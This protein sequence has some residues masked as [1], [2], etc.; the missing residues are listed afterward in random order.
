MVLRNHRE[1]RA[2][3]NHPFLVA[4]KVGRTR[5]LSWTSVASIVP[6]DELA[7]VGT[8][9]DHGRPHR[10]DPLPR[11][12]HSRNA[13]TAPV[14][15]SN[16]LLWLLG[17]YVGDGFFDG[18]N[19]VTF[20]VPD[21][22]SF[23]RAAARATSRGAGV[24]GARLRRARGDSTLRVQL[25]RRSSTGYRAAGFAGKAATKRLPDWTFR[26]PHA[27]QARLRRRLHRG[28]RARSRRASQHLDHEHELGRAA[29]AG[30][31]PRDL[32]AGIERDKDLDVDPTP[33]ARPLGPKEKELRRPSYLYFGGRD[34]RCPGA[35]R[36]G[37]HDRARWRARDL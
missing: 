37:P 11:R 2:T 22:D 6:G 27:Q 34:A 36:A 23:L 7:I 33:E 10:F 12:K 25:R 30:S 31:R 18:A 32:S 28:R 24:R 17:F 26:I 15:S 13:F 21:S 20:A 3:A 8:V 9:P 29:R 35:L 16:D 19:R 1:V 5:Q 14:E 4:R